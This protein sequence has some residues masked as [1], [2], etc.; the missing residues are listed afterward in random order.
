MGKYKRV[1][2]KLSGEALMGKEKT[3][4][5][6]NKQ[7]L[8]DIA[9]Q[10]KSI[11]SKGIKVGIVIGGGNIFRGRYCEDFSIE[12]S[13]GDYMGMVA[14]IFNS[15]SFRAALEAVGVESEVLSALAIEKVCLP[16]DEK[17]AN[18]Y[19]D[20]NKVVIFAAGTGKPYFSTDTCA[21]L[22]A[23]EMHA[24]VILMAK[25][26][27]EGVYNKDPRKYDDASMYD[28]ISYNEVLN[29]SLEVIDLSAINLC[30]DN[31]INLIVFNMDKENAIID[32]ANGVKIGT[33]IGEEK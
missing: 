31:K 10:V 33:L 3:G 12:R 19:F 13:K 2:L 22:R 14:T 4:G 7:V 26:G 25:N 6:L 18:Q 24:D 30:K 20:E 27:V 16:Y 17:L 21:A 8:F 5:V 11:V 23:N 1:L 29:Q 9:T 15:L 28:F 32:V